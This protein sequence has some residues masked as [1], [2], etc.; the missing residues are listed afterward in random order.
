MA[1]VRAAKVEVKSYAQANALLKVKGKDRVKLD[2]NTYLERRGDKSIAVLY[3]AT[4]IVTYTPWWIELDTGTWYTVSTASR[5]R[6]YIP[7]DIRAQKGGWSWYPLAELPCYCENDK[8]ASS[9]GIVVIGEHK[10]GTRPKFAERYEGESDVNPN[11]K[12]VYVYGTCETCGG[13]AKLMRVDWESGGHP[14]YDGL[15]IHPSGTRLMRTQPRE[16][17]AF[18]PVYTESGFTGRSLS[19]HY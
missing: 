15:R 8:L 19:R 4:D 17:R 10:P 12:P 16:P 6:D 14:F 5:M 3:H 2:R 9:G 13:S 7:G 1:V 11:G 18:R